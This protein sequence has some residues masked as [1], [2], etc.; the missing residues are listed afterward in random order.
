MRIQ[1]LK[2]LL[3]VLIKY[4]DIQRTL[5]GKQD[6]EYAN[7]YNKIQDEIKKLEGGKNE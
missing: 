2:Y 6:K 1:E 3:A 5:G 7:I 4:R